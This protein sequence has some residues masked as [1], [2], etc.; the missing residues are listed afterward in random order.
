MNVFGKNHELSIKKIL[1]R[2]T[3]SHKLI[4]DSVGVISPDRELFVT[5]HF[6][7]ERRT[8][9]RTIKLSIFELKRDSYKYLDEE[10]KKVIKKLF[11]KKKSI[12]S[13]F[14]K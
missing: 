4:I 12:L 6:K 13:N 10:I 1:E 8:T 9:D 7:R 2:I 14:I 3:N 11:P 5:I